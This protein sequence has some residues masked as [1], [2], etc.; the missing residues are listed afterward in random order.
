MRYSKAMTVVPSRNIALVNFCQ[1]FNRILQKL[2][3]RYVRSDK[4]D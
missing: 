4:N 1:A 2:L 3:D